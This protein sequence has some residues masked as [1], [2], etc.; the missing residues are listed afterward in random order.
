MFVWTICIDTIFNTDFE[1][2]EIPQHLF[3]DFCVY[4]WN[5]APLEETK[6]LS[7]GNGALRKGLG[8]G[9]GKDF[10]MKRYS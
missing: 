2:N 6:R 10:L 8:K 7:N 9:K 3:L 5:E 4:S 1:Q